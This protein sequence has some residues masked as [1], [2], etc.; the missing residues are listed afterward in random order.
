MPPLGLEHIDALYRFALRL[1]RHPEEAEDL[2]QETYSRATANRAQFQDGTNARGWLFRILRNAFIDRQ[3]RARRNP[4]DRDVD[5]EEASLEAAGEREPVRGDHE[6]D[7]LRGLVAADIEA[8]LARLSVDA[9]TIVLL[10]LEGLSEIEI[11]GVLDCPKGTV[12]SRLA[13]ARA[14]LRAHLQDY[15]R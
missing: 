10:D 15:A 2:V 6:L 5:V 4:I 8:A 12:K 1:T 14:A 13:R 9:R 3:R 7:R 11:A